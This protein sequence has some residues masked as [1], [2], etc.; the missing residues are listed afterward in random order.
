MGEATPE[1]CYRDEK[2]KPVQEYIERSLVDSGLVDKY[3]D[4]L[5]VDNLKS[6]I[7]DFV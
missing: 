2:A 5:L 1:R 7:K 6:M 3:E 4:K